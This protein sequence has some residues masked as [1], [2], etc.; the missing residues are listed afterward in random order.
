MQAPTVVAITGASGH[1]GAALVRALLARGC[2]VRV[3]DLRS[4]PGVGPADVDWREVN[5]LDA[6]AMRAGLEGVD[7][8]YHLA[9]VISIA[10]DPRVW[11]TNVDGVRTV[12][13]A[14]LRAGVRRFVH[15]SSVHAFDLERSTPLVTEQSPRSTEEP[16]VPVYDRSKAA[17][18][19]VLQDFI[20]RGLDAVIVNPTGVIG[21]FDYGPSRMGRTLAALSRNRIPA[22]VPGAF[23][24]VDNRD[25]AAALI[26]ACERG[27]TGHNYLVGGHRASLEDFAHIAHDV[28]GSAV[29][30]V[31]LP[32]GF[33]ETMSH[34]ALRLSG[35]RASSLLFTPDALHALRS[36]PQ[37]DDAKARRELD[38]RPRPLAQT[39]AD[40]LEWL[41]VQ[42]GDRLLFRAEK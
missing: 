21:P 20:A 8:A 14:A 38:H 39:V 30:R 10:G 1:V 18:E 7:V 3:L 5:V 32:W 36:D 4:P 15:C 31:A 26:A 13:E 24:W 12:A 17:G 11:R 41:G 25:V 16:R 34:V 37:V 29:P 6:E 33:A 9:A 22:L 19:R 42:K 23:N 40:T 2:T 35:P 28:C 27:H